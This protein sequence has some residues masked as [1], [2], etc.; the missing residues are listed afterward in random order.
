MAEENKKKD[1]IEDKLDRIPIIEKLTTGLITGDYKDG[2]VIGIDS[3]WGKGKT[4]FLKLWEQHLNDQAE[5][6]N[7]KY[8]NAW[9]NDNSDNPLLSL[10]LHLKDIFQEHDEEY[11]IN[12]FSKIAIKG[13]KRIPYLKDIASFI[14]DV[15][16]II[17]ENIISIFDEEEERIELTGKFKDALE[18]LSSKKK[19]IFFIDELDRCR[20]TYAIELLESI[21]HLFNVKNCI[22]I[23]AWD[24]SQ[25]SHSIKTIYGNE[26]DSTGYLRRFIDIDYKLPEPSRIKY[27]Q[28]IIPKDETKYYSYFYD[29]LPTVIEVHELSLRDID[30]LAMYL[31]INLNMTNL[32][33]DLLEVEKVFYSIL[34][35]LFL[36]IR[37][38][39]N[40]LYSRM[41]NNDFTEDDI[42]KNFK[43]PKIQNYDTNFSLKDN[44]FWFFCND[45]SLHYIYNDIYDD[46][47]NIDQYRNNEH[48]I[49]EQILRQHINTKAHKHEAKNLHYMLSIILDCLQKNTQKTCSIFEYNT[50]TPLYDGFGNYTHKFKQLPKELNLAEILSDTNDI[51]SKI[52]FWDDV[53]DVQ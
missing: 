5:E 49:Q 47:Q 1:S 13:L 44:T 16:N 12:M 27:A 6:Y 15:S 48:I 41:I 35:A 26:M 8:F 33:D 39:D 29:I 17:D 42:Q 21:K 53:Q 22:F 3:A 4:T 11:A 31:N 45:D 34:K 40:D 20:P 24:K 52:D 43:I 30:K 36:V 23:I 51:F 37:F 50:T 2:F 7:I 46:M 18:E 32:K 14:D 10:M 25:L 9:E 38:S 28:T 19:L